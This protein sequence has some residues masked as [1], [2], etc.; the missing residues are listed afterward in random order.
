[1]IAVAVLAIPSGSANAADFAL[2]A[3]SFDADDFGNSVGAGL[4]ADFPLGGSAWSTEFRASY[5]F[6]L[7]S[8]LN[9]FINDIDVDAGAFEVSA[10]PLDL[11]FNRAFGDEGF[12]LGG[13]ISFVQLDAD[14]E[15]VIDD[16]GG[17]Y[18]VTGYK[19]AVGGGTGF[20]FEL[21]YRGIE[22]TL[23]GQ[24]DDGEFFEIDG[25]MDGFTVNLG[26]V[27]RN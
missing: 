3:S 23:E 6:E 20:F 4:K 18:V 7:G 24:G 16:E 19:G 14:R 26:I 27:W 12:F 9:D 2:F 5:I 1:M 13:G 8:N 25:R 10:L 15:L 17:W 22:G 21:L 11:G